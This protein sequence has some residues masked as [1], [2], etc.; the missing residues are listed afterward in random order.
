MPWV[1]PTI[2]VANITHVL[3]NVDKYGACYGNVIRLI[4]DMFPGKGPEFSRHFKELLGDGIFS[5][6]RQPQLS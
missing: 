5:S 3:K 2:D 6:G 1:I 4:N